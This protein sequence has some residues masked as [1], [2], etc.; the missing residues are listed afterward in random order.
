MT[1]RG[2]ARSAMVQVCA[3]T[4][5]GLGRFAC[6]INWPESHPTSR[7]PTGRP[8]LPRSMRPLRV[9]RRDGHGQDGA[10]DEVGG[11]LGRRDE[12]AHR[13]RIALWWIPARPLSTRQG[14]VTGDD[15]TDAITRPV[16]VPG[17][18]ER[19]GTGA[20]LYAAPARILVRTH[21]DMTNG[22]RVSRTKDISSAGSHAGAVFGV[23]PAPAEIVAGGRSTDVRSVLRDGAV[24]D[25]SRA[26]RIIRCRGGTRRP[27]VRTV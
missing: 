23:L 20:R 16:V 12:A 3:R 25:S 13:D 11:G 9:G 24:I 1:P 6:A 26:G 7:T 14:P 4:G 2:P 21:A 15:V 17:D 22:G 27:A 8:Q 10:D 5:R 18:D 19:R